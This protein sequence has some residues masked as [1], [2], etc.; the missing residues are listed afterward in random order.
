MI[1]TGGWK[2][3]TALG[4]LAIPLLTAGCGLLPGQS[5][6]QIDPPMVQYDTGAAEAAQAGAA[7]AESAVKEKGKQLTVYL[8]DSGDYLAPVTIMADTGEEAGAAG[9]IALEMMVEDGP[10][11]GELP[12]GFRGILPKGTSIN[13]LHIDAGQKLA[14]VDF[15]KPFTDYSL[16]DERK[17]VEA[18]TWTLTGISGVEQVQILHEGE[19]LMEM[20]VDGYPLSKPLTRQIGINLEVGPGVEHSQSMPVT[21]YFSAL[22]EDNE[23]YYVPVTRL[24]DRSGEPA[25]EALQQLI[26]GPLDSR[27]LNYVMTSDVQVKAISQKGDTVMVELNE[28][29]YEE[30]QQLP[31]EMLQAVVLS[32]TENTGAAKVLIRVNGLSDVVDTNNRSYAEPV[33][34]PDFVNALKA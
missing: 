2:R 5:A 25:K 15:T 16:Q 7:L 18:I 19:K 10:H 20:P 1:R 9:R 23:Q 4:V 26:A 8:K 14:T 3:R 27:E 21:L 32:V 12:V 30:G 24:V 33:G 17:I 29:T 13:S 34:R 22:S 6:E 28:E 31:A 11:A